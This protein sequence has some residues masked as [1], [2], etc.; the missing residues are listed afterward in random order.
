MTTPSPIPPHIELRMRQCGET[1]WNATYASDPNVTQKKAFVEGFYIALSL[2]VRVSAKQ[3]LELE[4]WR[5]LASSML[6]GLAVAAVV[7]GALSR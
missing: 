2:G 6:I 7:V 5:G 1:V 3:Q 4:L